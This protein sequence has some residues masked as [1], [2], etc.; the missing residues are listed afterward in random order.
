MD[1]LILG[2]LPAHDCQPVWIL[3]S[4]LQTHAKSFCLITHG[5]SIRGK[6]KDTTSGLNF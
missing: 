4:H 6:M 1:V 5:C 2:S 3:A